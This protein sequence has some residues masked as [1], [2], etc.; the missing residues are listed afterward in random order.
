MPG[1]D[2][3]PVVARSDVV[4]ARAALVAGR[5]GP[6]LRL[7]D[8][9][10]MQLVGLHAVQVGEGRRERGVQLGLLDPRAGRRRGDGDD[11]DGDGEQRGQGQHG[12]EQDA[13]AGPV[14]GEVGEVAAHEEPVGQRGGG[15]R[16]GEADGD[17]DHERAE[18]A[19][20]R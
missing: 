8:G 7:R 9:G 16:P 6:Q 11:R 2:A 15:D 19:P 4:D 12:A 10:A 18:L 17:A 5:A 13:A 3:A 1:D 20:G 14:V